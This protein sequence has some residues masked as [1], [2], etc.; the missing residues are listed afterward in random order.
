M[1]CCSKEKCL[2]Q[3]WVSLKFRASRDS[4][5]QVRV[6]Y[7]PELQVLMNRFFTSAACNWWCRHHVSINYFCIFTLGVVIPQATALGWRTGTESTARFLGSQFLPVIADRDTWVGRGKLAQT[8]FHLKVQKILNCSPSTAVPKTKQ[9][10]HSYSRRHWDAVRL[11]VFAC[12][13]LF[14][15]LRLL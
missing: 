8:P 1:C 12:Q 5:S 4:Q 15:F 9:K 7:R 3:T 10:Q 14:G 11:A 13:L 6:T 2:C